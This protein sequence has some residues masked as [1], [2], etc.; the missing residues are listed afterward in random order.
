MNK[1][2]EILR[3]IDNTFLAAANLIRTKH[4]RLEKMIADP[5]NSLIVLNHYG[6]MLKSIHDEFT[7]TVRAI[8]NMIDASGQEGLSPKT[9]AAVRDLQTALHN[10][11]VEAHTAYGRIEH[12]LNDRGGFFASSTVHGAPPDPPWPPPTHTDTP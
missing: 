8:D 12:N 4:L 7:V 1:A 9:G 11:G 5:E 3:R 6:E 10:M 2:P